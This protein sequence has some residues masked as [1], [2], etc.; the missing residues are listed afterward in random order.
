MGLTNL[1]ATCYLNVL[2][3]CM[4]FNRRFR[5]AVYDF[6]GSSNDPSSRT[7]KMALILQVRSE[8]C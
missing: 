1:G 3:Q 8:A 5:S 4:F 6:R 2:L 7:G